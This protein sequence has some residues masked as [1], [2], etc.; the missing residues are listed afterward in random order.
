MC[1]KPRSGTD[2][3]IGHI[4]FDISHLSH[5]AELSGSSKELI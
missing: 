1:Q 2:K 3:I 5:V 4:S